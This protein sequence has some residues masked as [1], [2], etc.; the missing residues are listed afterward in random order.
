MDNLSRIKNISR[1]IYK[2]FSFLLVLIPLYYIF[3]W[4]LIN[5]LPETL[6]TVNTSSTPFVPHG[7]PMGLRILGLLVSLLPLT[8]LTFVLL[9]IRKLF[10]FYRVGVIFSYEHVILFKNIAKALVFWVV[11]SIIYESAKSVLFTW[12]NPP[13]ERLLEI[14]FSSGEATTLFVGA[15]V[16][17]IA[18]V[19]DE[20]RILVEENELTI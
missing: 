16:F 20:G 7:L 10:S 5:H 8:A 12:G 11:F 3:Y 9:N 4:M 6:I 15:M 17:V 1:K 18:W 19:M 14:G 13:G 2:L